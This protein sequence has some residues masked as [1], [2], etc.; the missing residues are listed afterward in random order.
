MFLPSKCCHVFP[1]RLKKW[2]TQIHSVSLPHCLCLSPGSGVRHGWGECSGACSHC[3]HGAHA[4]HLSLPSPA[5][6][7]GSPD[8]RYTPAERQRM[9]QVRQQRI[10]SITRSIKSTKTSKNTGRPISVTVL[11]SYFIKHSSGS[12]EKTSCTSISAHIFSWG[13][14]AT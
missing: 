13:Q 14:A 9:K 11:G 5:H 6:A 4:S 2:D 7:I 8:E 10:K 12:A 3:V 1:V